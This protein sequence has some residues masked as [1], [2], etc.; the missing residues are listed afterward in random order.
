MPFKS[1]AIFLHFETT[2]PTQQDLDEIDNVLFLTPRGF[3][4][5]HSDVFSRH[6]GS[7]LDHNNKLLPEE[8]RP[9]RMLLADI[10]EDNESEKNNS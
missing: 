5:P 7:M 10:E 9:A 2:K 3:W 8:D 6:E 4:D 1:N